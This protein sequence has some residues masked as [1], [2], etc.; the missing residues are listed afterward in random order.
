[1]QEC[2]RSRACSSRVDLALQVLQLDPDQ[3]DEVVDV[4]TGALD[5]LRA[6]ATIDHHTGPQAVRLT[7]GAGDDDQV[8]LEARDH[9]STV[10]PSRTSSCHHL[11]AIAEVG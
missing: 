11:V 8:W 5:P 1:M 2:R 4:A 3:L 9:M 6:V 7:P 10:A